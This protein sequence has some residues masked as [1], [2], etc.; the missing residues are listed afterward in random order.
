MVDTNIIRNASNNEKMDYIELGKELTYEQKFR[1]ELAAKEAE[2]TKA[3]K[4]FDR[5]GAYFDFLD[6][7]AE[8]VKKYERTYGDGAGNYVKYEDFKIDLD[9]YGEPSRFK[10]LEE[11][12]VQ[13][14]K[15]LDGVRTAV[16]T[17]K[18]QNFQCVNHK[19]RISVFVPK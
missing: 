1:K 3:H 4:P 9:K 7:K 17:G 14:M 11:S 19:G 8:V 6:K 15:L 5:K 10:L 12:E 18:Y 13:E 16:I 2:Y